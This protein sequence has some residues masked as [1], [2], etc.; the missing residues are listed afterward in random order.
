MKLHSRLKNGLTDRSCHSGSSRMQF[1]IA[2]DH[3][4]VPVE[5]LQFY[6]GWRQTKEAYAAVH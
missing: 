2:V 6:A 3:A 5:T 4:V 1:S